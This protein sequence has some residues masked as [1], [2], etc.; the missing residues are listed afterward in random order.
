MAAYEHQPERGY[1]D[2]ELRRYVFEC[3]RCGHREVP[4]L[5]VP[6]RWAALGLDEGGEWL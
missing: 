6:S 2:H 5:V 4:S 3:M 1:F